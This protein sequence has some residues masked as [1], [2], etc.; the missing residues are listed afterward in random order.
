M[1]EHM[2]P[3]TPTSF[4]QQS[5]TVHLSKSDTTQILT[6][7]TEP[8]SNR[9]TTPAAETCPNL[10]N[11]II[12]G[13]HT[14]HEYEQQTFSWISRVQ[15]ENN[16]GTVQYIQSCHCSSVRGGL[17][18]TLQA[19]Q[20]TLSDPRRHN[21]NRISLI[22]CSRDTKLLSAIRRLRRPAQSARSTLQ[23]EHTLLLQLATTLKQFRKYSTHQSTKRENQESNLATI[24]KSC[25]DHVTNWP[26]PV[27]TTYIPQ[28]E[29]ILWQDKHE[30]STD[31]ERTI[32][33]SASTRDLRDYMTT[34]YQW[35]DDTADHIDWTAHAAALLNFPTNQRKTITQLIHKWL[36][37][38]GHPGRHQ[39]TRN[40][41]CPHCQ[42]DIESQNHFLIC[43]TTKS[44][45]NSQLANT[46]CS[47]LT[48]TSQ[49][50][51]RTILIWALTECRNTNKTLPTTA[52]KPQRTQ[53][54]RE[55]SEIGWNQILKG[56]WST[57]WVRQLD[58]TSP[59]NGEKLTITL[60]TRIWTTFTKLWHT[61][62]DKQHLRVSPTYLSNDRA[63]SRRSKQ[64]MHKNKTSI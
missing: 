9:I 18:S 41:M 33:H 34:K 22:I 3:V 10:H 21:P 63:Y 60:I 61:R 46:V 62:C 11:K 1:N 55:Q 38:N 53:L 24:M 44:D 17:I 64:S 49:I 39:S 31:I 2:F 23:P 6:H 35:K 40:K 45:W 32:R 19:I 50:P 15:N 26:K 59:S 14:I 30:I 4:T 43:D 36:P 52:N 58:K 20:H 57:E 16:K 27:P 37:V 25:I 29:A 51:L 7:H 54:I 8:S 42:R 48:E 28:G 5:L 47:E 13:I 56:R 12:I